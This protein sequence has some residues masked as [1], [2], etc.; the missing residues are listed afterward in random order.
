M[1]I[2]G[3]QFNILCPIFANPHTYPKIRCHLWMSPYKLLLFFT[4]SSGIPYSVCPFFLIFRNTEILANFSSTFSFS[5][6]YFYFQIYLYYLKSNCHS[7]VRCVCQKQRTVGVPSVLLS[8]PS[9]ASQLSYKVIM[10]VHI[11]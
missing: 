6:Q 2:I 7:P 10:N 11:T 5:N 3:I 8:D 1:T 9:G 4:L